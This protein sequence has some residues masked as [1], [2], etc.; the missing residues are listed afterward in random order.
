MLTQIDTDDIRK[1]PS[2]CAAPLLT[3][4]S[5]LAARFGSPQWSGFFNTTASLAT[6]GHITAG[7]GDLA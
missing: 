2:T 5:L 1:H 6:R 7:G 3:N 4:P